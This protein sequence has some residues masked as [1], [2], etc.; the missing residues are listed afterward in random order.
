M[1]SGQDMAQMNAMLQ[2]APKAGVVQTIDWLDELIDF[3]STHAQNVETH[4]KNLSLF[5]APNCSGL[6]LV[7]DCDAQ[8]LIHVKFKEACDLTAIQIRADQKPQGERYV[9]ECINLFSN[10]AHELDFD[11]ANNANANYECHMKEEDGFILDKL[12]GGSSFRCVEKITIFIQNNHSGDE[13]EQSFLNSIR[14]QGKPSS[15]MNIA[16]WKPTKG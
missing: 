9:P 15:A 5:L 2:K 8:M 6:A 10:I 1:A 4:E 14:F 3:S 11:D 7:S 16:D 12:P 13:D